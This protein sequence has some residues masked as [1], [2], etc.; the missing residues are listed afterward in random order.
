MNQG[1]PTCFLEC[2]TKALAEADVHLATWGGLDLPTKGWRF[3]RRRGATAL[4]FVRLRVY[5]RG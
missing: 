3:V 2:Y 4:I 1:T 5:D